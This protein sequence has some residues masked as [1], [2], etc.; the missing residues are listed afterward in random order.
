MVIPELVDFCNLKCALCWNRNRK[1]SFRQMPL[2]TVEKVIDVFGRNENYHWYN[3]GEPLFYE[4]FHEFAEIA[5]N[6]RSTISSNFSMPLTEQHFEDLAKLRQV[7]LSLSGLTRDI[8]GIYHQGGNFD[9][10]MGNVR[11]LVGTPVNVIVNWIRHPKNKHQEKLS[12]EW[13][14]D[15]EFGWG[16]VDLNCEVEEQLQE[17]THPF[18]K[19]MDTYSSKI[20]ECKIKKWVPISVDGE[21]LLCCASHNVGTGYTIWDNISREELVEI[22]SQMTLCKECMKKECWR[23]Y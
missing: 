13:S 20:K 9:A 23:M 2:K 8:Y 16:C 10:V 3:W 11:H 17:F 7:I 21:Y 4:N 18:L 15:R 12:Q 22:K 1:G 6:V 5:K 19:G 14:F